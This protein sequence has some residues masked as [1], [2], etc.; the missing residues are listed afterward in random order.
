M[1]LSLSSP[2]G[3]EGGFGWL[4][5]YFCSTMDHPVYC[6]QTLFLAFNWP[7]PTASISALSVSFSHTPFLHLFLLLH[8]IR[9]CIN[10]ANG[11]VRHGH[12]SSKRAPLTGVYFRP[13]TLTT[14][15][16]TSIWPSQLPGFRPSLAVTQTLSCTQIRATT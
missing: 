1:L 16:S 6:S 15:K 4:C 12:R 10:G 13:V 14:A 5:Y 2:R 9:R 8:S 3:I 11:R 7:L